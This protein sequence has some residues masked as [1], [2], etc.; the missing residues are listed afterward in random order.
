MLLLF[1]VSVAVGHLHWRRL[2]LALHIT[3]Q[4]NNCDI[5][6][7]CIESLLCQGV[8]SS[9]KVVWITATMPYVVLSILLAR[10]F[11]TLPMLIILSTIFKNENMSFFVVFPTGA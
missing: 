2:L 1:F 5:H 3:L 4:G 9:G 10:S 7:M 8:K 6:S 11:D